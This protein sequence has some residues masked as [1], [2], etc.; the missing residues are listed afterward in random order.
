[1]EIVKRKDALFLC[2]FFYPEYNSSATLPW[3]TARFLANEG[4]SIGALCGY[5]KEY[6]NDSNVPLV[7]IKENV[8][9]KRLKYLQLKRGKKF[10]RLIN[11]FSFTFSVFLHVGELRKYKSVFVYSN[12]P[13]LPIVPILAKILFDTKIIFVSYDVY[14]EVAYASGSLIENGVIAK[15]MR[16]INRT[17]SK[18]VSFVV[19]L[20]EEMKE[21]LLNSRPNLKRE[22][23]R[24]I[25][26][27]AHESTKACDS[28]TY[29]K[30]GYSENDFIVSY[31]GNMGI[32]Q[33]ME[34]FIQTMKLMKDDPRI[35]FFI[36]G[37]GGKMQHVIEE[38]KNL[39]NVQVLQFLTGDDFEDAVAISSCSIVS[40]EA[41]LRGMCAPSKFYSYLQ[42]G[43]P[44]IS[45][46]EKGSYL[47]DEIKKESIGKAITIGDTQGLI[48]AI[49]ALAHD[50]QYRYTLAKNASDLYER[51]YTM[52]KC[53][54]KYADMLAELV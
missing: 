34:T 13:V 26:N 35:K 22:Q 15:T 10:S 2:Q 27:W 48:D 8:A 44:V 36:V 3:D 14:P 46:T 1:M 39:K 41:G 7:E 54:N 21:F 23:V 25:P 11:Y 52:Q 28:S 20:T 29:A 4:Y 19:S 42:G 49:Y 17:L 45:I 6:N 37:H 40:L 31:F 51:K 16:M 50:E 32:C 5:P 43:I 30:F 53:L 33:E 38:T 47:Q 12:P 9:I 24:V 18:K